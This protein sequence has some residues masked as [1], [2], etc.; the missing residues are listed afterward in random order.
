MRCERCKT[1]DLALV[2]FGIYDCPVCGR[3][4]AD[5]NLLEAQAG[6]D[7]T[8]PVTF[9]TVETERG[10]FAAPPPVGSPAAGVTPA[11]PSGKHDVPQVFLWT[12]GLSAI[13][14]L[15]AVIA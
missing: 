13:L 14:D 2:T 1:S 8:G 11:A 15:A 9:G 10:S 3:V 12:A 6:A 5:G 7:D 4:D